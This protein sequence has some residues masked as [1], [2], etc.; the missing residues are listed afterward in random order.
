MAELKRVFSSAKMNKDM[1]ERLVP[2]G[3]YRDANN[4]EIATSEGSNVGT[5]Q[6]ILS[7]TER[8]TLD[9]GGVTTSILNARDVN[10]LGPHDKSTCVAS[11]AA[12]NRDRIYY[13][14]SAGD[15][16]STSGLQSL[17]KDYII[18]YNTVSEKSKYVFV[19]I[20]RSD[21]T[22]S[23]SPG[24]TTFHIA[25]DAGETINK[26]GIRVGM[27]IG[28]SDTEVSSIAYDTSGETPINKW[29]ITTNKAHNLD[30]DDSVSFKAPRV[31]K[32]SKRNIITGINILDDFIFWTDN[33][34]EPK[35]INILRSIAGTGGTTL[36]NTDP[37]DV[38]IG[39]YDYFHTR[40][41]K[42]KA[43]TADAEN[44]YTID[45]GE[46]VEEANV[47]VI[48]KGPTQPLELEMFR[49]SSKRVDD[50]GDETAITAT[51]T[52]FAYTDAVGQLF[53]TDT[54]AFAVE[55]IDSVNFKENDIVLISSEE[56]TSV[57]Y[58][59]RA[60][61]V[62][63]N[64]TNPNL[65]YSDGFEIKIL[66]I[67]EDIGTNPQTWKFKLEDTRPIFENMFPRFSY[68]YKYQDGEYSTFAPWSAVGFLPDEYEY[69]PKKGYNLGMVNQLRSLKLKGYFAKDSIRPKDLSEID[70]LYK[71]AGKPAVYTVKTIKESDGGL[72]WPNQASYPKERGEFTIETD[73][74]HAVVPSNQILRPWDNVPRKAL[75]QEISA[76]RLIYGNYLQNYTVLED[77]IIKISIQQN[78]LSLLD[79]RSSAPSVKTMRKYQVGVVFSDDYGRETPVLTT[80]KSSVTVL[81]DASDKRSRLVCSLDKSTPNIPE[82]AKYLSYY[83]K[84]TSVE[85]YSMAMDRWYMASDGNVWLS[86]PSSERNKLD[87]ETFIVLKKAHGSNV[88]V[89]DKARYRILAIENEAP[90]HVK[91]ERKS[92]GKLFDNGNQVVGDEGEGWPFVDNTFIYI[93]ATEF[94]LAFGDELRLL[95][96]DSMYLRLYGDG[97]VSNSYEIS[98]ITSAGGGAQGDYYKV[99]L[100]GKF[101]EDISF[102]TTDG[103]YGTAIQDLSVEI[104]EYEV[105]NRP[106]FDGR[107]FVKIHSD[108]ALKEYVLTNQQS[109]TF[110][111]NRQSLSYLNNNGYK[112]PD[113]NTGEAT[114]NSELDTSRAEALEQNQHFQHMFG[115]YNGGAPGY[116]Y[117]TG[118]RNV[119]MTGLHPTENLH[120]TQTLG[121]GGQ[122][123]NKYW[124]GD[125]EE[126]TEGGANSERDR[127]GIKQKHIMGNPVMALND[128]NSDSGMSQHFWEKLRG[129]Y[130]FF[131]DSST[132]FSY[133][134]R[135]GYS[136]AEAQDN[137]WMNELGGSLFGHTQFFEGGQFVSSAENNQN[138]DNIDVTGIYFQSSAEGAGIPS[139]GIW[140]VGS[141]YSYMDIS[142][143]GLGNVHNH[144]QKLGDIPDG[145]DGEGDGSQY[146]R[147]GQFI[148]QLATPGTRFRFAR[149]PDKHVYEVLE[150][151]FPIYGWAGQ[152]GYGAPAFFFNPGTTSR[153]TGVWGM[154]NYK[155]YGYSDNWNTQDKNQY[156]PSQY[157]QRWTLTVSPKI[158][159]RGPSFYSPTTGT[160]GY[161]PQ[162]DGTFV[163][164]DANAPDKDHV[165]YRRAL[166]HD[167][168]GE[169]DAIEIVN[170]FDDTTQKGGFTKNPAV[171]ETE[172]KESVEL[173]IYYQASGLIPLELNNKTNE[174][175]VS[176]GSTFYSVNYDDPAADFGVSS[177]KHTVTSLDNRT[178]TFTPAWAGEGVSSGDIIKFTKRDN[179]SFE[180]VI[181]GQVATGATT[182]TLL[183]GPNASLSNR[184]A[185]QKQY[186]DW[187]NCWAFGNGVESDRVR[188]DFN[189]AQIDNGVKAST[190]LAEQ[191]REERRKHGLI[192]SGIYNSNSG[193]NDTN[194]FIAAEK[195]TK[196][197]NPI[198]G[199]IQA[200]LNK[201][202]RL[203]MFCE[204][205]VLRGV[206]NKD[207]LYNADGNPQ[208]VSSNTVIGDVTPYQGD[209]GISTNP[210]SIATTPST[211]YFT[212]AVKGR[213][214][215]LSTEGI[216]PISDIGMKGYFSDFMSANIST[217]LG[218]Y[219]DRKKEYNISMY[220][221]YNAIQPLFHE[222]VT[223]SYSEIS[224]GW[225]SFKS[226]Y[227]QAGL[228]L[229]G[230]Y[231]TFSNGGL[232][233]H[234]LGNS[235]NTIYGGVT[236]SDI[237]VLFNDQPD[238]S[239]KFMTI[240]YE[241]SKQNI[242]AFATESHNSTYTGNSDINEG[243]GS[244]DFTDSEY[245]NLSAQLGWSAE[246][247][248][249][250][251]QSCSNL[252]FKDKEGKYFSY[253]TGE[254]TTLSNLDEKEFTVQGIGLANITHS[255]AS[256]GN[257]ITIT[258]ANN[259]SRTYEGISGTGTAWDTNT[260]TTETSR[261]SVGEAYEGSAEVVASAGEAIGSGVTR[262]LTITPIVN[263]VYSGF[264]LSASNFEWSG[265]TNSSG[266][267]WDN[268]DGSVNADP[269]HDA[270]HISRITFTDIG[271]PGTASN[272]VTAT[273]QFN[274]SATWPSASATWYVDID[275]KATAPE[276][277]TRDFYLKTEYDY[278]GGSQQTTPPGIATPSGLSTAVIDTGGTSGTTSNSHSG[279]VLNNTSTLI[280][281]LSFDRAEAY[282]YLGGDAS[283]SVTFENLGDYAGSYTSSITNVVYSQPNHITNFKVKIYYT[284]PQSGLAIEDEATMADLGH[285]AIVNYIMRPSNTAVT[286]DIT[287][288]THASE[289]PYG[290]AS[291]PVVVYGKYNASYRIF[292]QKKTSTSSGA[293]SST[294]GYYNFGTDLFQNAPSHEV[295]TINAQGTWLHP[296]VLPPVLS[297]TRYDITIEALNGPVLGSVTTL[298]PQVPTHPG[299]AVVIHNGRRTL[300]IKP[301]ADVVANFETID[302]THTV[303]VSKPAISANVSNNTKSSDVYSATTGSAIS[304][305]TK[306]ALA[307]GAKLVRSGMLVLAP[308]QASGALVIPLG[309]TITSVRRNNIVL[310][311]ACT[312]P[313][314]T[315]LS[316]VSSATDL[317]PFTI[318]VEAAGTT[319]NT[320]FA[321][322]S[323]I[324]Y[325]S[326]IGGMQSQIQTLV[327]TALSGGRT[328]VLDSNR[329]IKVGM[330]VT[331][332]GIV[333]DP[334]L[335]Y[336]K[337]ETVTVAGK[338]TIIFSSDQTL[339][340]DTSLIFSWPEDDPT[341][342]VYNE[343]GGANAGVVPRHIMA[344][345]TDGDTVKIEG[346]IQASSITKDDT[347]DIYIN[348]F[349][350]VT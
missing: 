302:A 206:T 190:V 188:D 147:A 92:L 68:R 85:Y 294:G 255:D 232:W 101:N 138:F 145:L 252:Y 152:S 208:L 89:K 178:V 124:W 126:P 161:V 261:W 66:S 81:K 329:G 86:F 100:A 271:Q 210:E 334:A 185:F 180:A 262:V 4:I 116:N 31:L 249:T 109:N 55:F 310:S 10:V 285:K 239:K 129:E 315:E 189:T 225:V 61:I 288:V 233:Q 311:A 83:I 62:S 202:T 134:A 157:R 254:A 156:H 39:D 296:V 37:S 23:A 290:P 316:F 333:P 111:S 153:F 336:A 273:L 160:G 323:G 167:Y 43:I 298:G 73:I 154:R 133:T 170:V 259:T 132:A 93:K 263:G 306:L 18:E 8:N 64:V 345:I 143:S 40:I 118:V 300:S 243:I 319:N 223:V 176:L 119:S 48:R 51:Q 247:F 321:L 330:M 182:L 337:V 209:Y 340:E 203:V 199:S 45:G 94:I 196:D 164:E 50:E 220:K 205:K 19:D 293:T 216:R 63:S 327:A 90:D 207:A 253:P 304:S 238:T 284:P 65:L 307:S 99:Q 57:D 53:T 230:N 191:T 15:Y 114:I 320:S 102:T 47:T 74:I 234:Y 112:N 173:D 141:E 186:L 125:M 60:E 274:S 248:T 158:G 181:G 297:D 305:S 292:V 17:R 303:L 291:V 104:L 29:K 75:A 183:G 120:H 240:N 24:T 286:Y 7:N 348:D 70:L 195:I 318:N 267:L 69:L 2:N 341:L 245:Y 214:L 226:F 42:N 326:S 338:T 136:F 269:A 95:P 174:E 175:Y 54:A 187:S 87:N 137:M 27:T 34:S 237:T 163:A 260:A 32:F 171:W 322:K 217:C 258:L 139:R 41:A 339:A 108:A 332:T 287:S 215:A 221:K 130:G 46:P 270:G 44:I 277:E 228:S 123:K 168:S 107:F 76:N 71:E 177:T 295:G 117:T 142:W 146:Y 231:Y 103:T 151:D 211:T 122:G 283:P 184:I 21:T 279:S 264:P 82:W 282:Y 242:P 49:T 212:D 28:S 312:I 9:Q 213:V 281:T 268:T 328:L 35:K 257:Q 299:D 1:D 219:D 38:F 131:I 344:S 317:I 275:D 280:T 88:A 36:L 204:D 30:A 342:D 229:N 14:V 192:W 172:P 56:S 325:R 25:L 308:F 166:H 227:P 276:S 349:V 11:V 33:E 198:Y 289:V 235:Y 148:E 222:Q 3:Q 128:D 272:T 106:E 309:V 121:N 256:V 331:G 140:H 110:V 343:F 155:T 115:A 16:Y 13:F 6:T 159:L 96:P 301:Y 78:K 278:L 169:K 241:G 162:G 5:V 236:Y 218:S 127:W 197:L 105:E 314:G 80:K 346:Y 26:T 266:N 179:Y 313:A 194:Q 79:Y 347:L 246:S 335:G 200:L 193:V 52:D 350:N 113:P 324:D 135:T 201:D 244:V 91:T 150:D 97:R 250:N 251:L 22:V 58:A 224:K 144:F 72:E 98:R 265:A 149:D 84:E 59:I 12:P 165:N 77:P 20:F 67:N